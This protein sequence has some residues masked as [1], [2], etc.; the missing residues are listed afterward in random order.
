M[1]V[2]IVTRIVRVTGNVTALR[3]G[4]TLQVCTQIN[5]TQGFLSNNFLLILM[6]TNNCVHFHDAYQLQ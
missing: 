2:Q 4:V 5:L 1:E 6:T 3:Y